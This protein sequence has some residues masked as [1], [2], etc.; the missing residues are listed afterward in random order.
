MTSTKWIQNRRG[1]LSAR[2][3]S[4]IQVCC[5][6]EFGGEEGY[7]TAEHLF[8]GAIELCIMTTFNWLLEKMGCE[9]ISY[10]SE[11]VGVAQIVD[12][13]FRFVEM[14]IKPVITVPECHFSR[15][16]DAIEHAHKQCLISKAL[17]FKVKVSATLKSLSEKNHLMT[18]MRSNDERRGDIKE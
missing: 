15:A 8:V 10:E 2:N 4:A 13:D 9:L 7:W 18:L 17:N 11:A 12:G 3:K 16:E 5:P 14:E 1:V 6:P